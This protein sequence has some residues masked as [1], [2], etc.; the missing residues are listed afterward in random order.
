METM[1]RQITPTAAKAIFV[2]ISVLLFSGASGEE[3]PT[4]SNPPPLIL[5]TCIEV[6]RGIGPNPFSRLSNDLLAV[7]AY[8][9]KPETSGEVRGGGEFLNLYLVHGLLVVPGV[10][11]ALAH[12]THLIVGQWLYDGGSGNQ[13]KH[14]WIFSDLDRDGS[15]DKL[16]FKKVV[17][18]ASGQVLS[19]MEVQV[20]REGLQPMESYFNEARRKMQQRTEEASNR[21]CMP[22]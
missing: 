5:Q 4:W 9:E 17:K 12:E 15:L 18:D 7:T 19:L 13:T 22:V 21:S 20:P 8:E 1:D 16:V 10:P 3:A 6:S 11:A 2:A 14:E